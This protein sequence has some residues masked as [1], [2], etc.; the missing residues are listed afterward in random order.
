METQAFVSA[1]KCGAPA[2]LSFHVGILSRF[3]FR[4][5]QEEWLFFFLLWIRPFRLPTLQSNSVNR[6]FIGTTEYFQ[7]KDIQYCQLIMCPVCVLLNIS[8]AAF[9]LSPVALAHVICKCFYSAFISIKST[10]QIK[11]P[12]FLSHFVATKDPQSGFDELVNPNL[13]SVVK[14]EPWKG[15]SD[16]FIGRESKGADRQGPCY[17]PDLSTIPRVSSSSDCHNHCSQPATLFKGQ[18][19]C[20]GG[21]FVHVQ[22][23]RWPH[24]NFQ[25]CLPAMHFNEAPV[26]RW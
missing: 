9:L 22:V 12:S 21:V 7:I 19:M 25:I 11:P 3:V 14:A 20:L 23:A 13:Q 15:W 16:G 5:Q 17:W 4:W 18:K 6:P 2:Y 10:P 1:V 24:R 26:R 8:T